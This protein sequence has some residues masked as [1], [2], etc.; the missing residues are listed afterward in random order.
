MSEG[1]RKPQ[2][3]MTVSDSFKVFL[4]RAINSDFKEGD[5]E[6]GY[7]KVVHGLGGYIYYKRPPKDMMIW[8]VVKKRNLRDDIIDKELKEKLPDLIY[9]V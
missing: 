2:V 3:K 9:Y 7:T 1:K 4:S 6:R 5:L 8:A